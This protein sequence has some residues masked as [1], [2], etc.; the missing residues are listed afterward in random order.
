MMRYEHAGN[1]RS[2]MAGYTLIEMLVVVVVMGILLSLVSVIATPD[3]R[4][5]LQ[6]ETERLAQLL[7]LAA[8]ES[9]LTGKAIRWASDGAG[10]H[11]WRLHE[12]GSW[13]EIQGNDELLHPRKLPDGMLITDFRMESMQRLDTMRVDFVPY[14][15]SLAYTIVM[16]IGSERA[17][18]A[19]SPVGDAISSTRPENA[20]GNP[21][22]P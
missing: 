7:N 8:A 11:F 5:R 9:R 13:R 20:N 22:Q 14:G 6:V 21:A 2:P 17:S 4:N 18:I 15:L 1:G 16:T 19:A 3:A 12:D 10:Y